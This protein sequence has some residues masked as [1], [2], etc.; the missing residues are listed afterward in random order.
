MTI[1]RNGQR[2]HIW[3]DGGYVFVIINDRVSVGFG[4]PNA[5][6]NAVEAV[7]SLLDRHAS[8]VPQLAA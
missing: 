6:E 3:T 4:G 7:A 1:S 2:A 5:E 8:T